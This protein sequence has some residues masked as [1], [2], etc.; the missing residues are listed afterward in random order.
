MVVQIIQ[1]VDIT[2]V[3]PKSIVHVQII[4]LWEPAHQRCYCGYTGSDQTLEA[5]LWTRLVY[6]HGAADLKQ[7]PYLSSVANYILHGLLSLNCT[8][9]VYISDIDTT[10][11]TYV[12]PLLGTHQWQ[13]CPSCHRGPW[14][15]QH[16]GS[17]SCGR[18]L[19]Q[20]TGWGW[21]PSWSVGSPDPYHGSEG[22]REVERAVGREGRTEGGRERR[23]GGR[24]WE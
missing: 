21:H 15:L 23:E 22:G 4:Q 24:M 2:S 19:L 13:R 9:Y 18:S 20:T 7:W 10:I 1:S 17:G 5:E 3:S 16:R 6:A 8:Q 12:I 11:L 14:A